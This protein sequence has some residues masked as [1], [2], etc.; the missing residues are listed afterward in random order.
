MAYF[1]AGMGCK[2]QTA[3]VVIDGAQQAV[4]TF[5]P[6]DP[7]RGLDQLWNADSWRARWGPMAV[8][9][10]KEAM[11]H[12]GGIPPENLK[13]RMQMMLGRAAAARAAKT[14]APTD[15]RSD[16]GADR[17]TVHA[18]HDRH[19]GYF[20]TREMT[21]Q[22]PT[23]DG[24]ES[25]AVTREVFVATDAAIVLPYDPVRDRVLLV[26]QF[27]IGPFGR[28]D[29]YPWA[30]EPVA[31]RMDPGESA[32][33]TVRRECEE[34]AGLTLKGLEHIS[35]HYAS[36]GC[37]TEYFHC[38]LGVC[39]L[40]DGHVGQGGLD[41]EDE[42]IR[43]HILPFDRAMDLLTTGEAENGP[44]ILCLMWLSIHRKRLRADA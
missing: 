28:G 16:L 39:D 43:I 36:P 29:P 11:A 17:V 21:L 30:L 37:T 4:T 15:L 1:A 6:Q 3:D 10:A 13:T 32:E 14:P 44:L 5:L 41:S 12:R 25:R 27:R 19:I 18:Q 8:L 22:H 9:A 35:S 31:G 34:E 42:D 20:L 24:G 23:F 26:E 33:T 7:A 2:V 38:Y 40:P